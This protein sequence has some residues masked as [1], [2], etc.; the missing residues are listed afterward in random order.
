MSE[1]VPLLRQRRRR[2]V[3]AAIVLAGLIVA[4]RSGWLLVGRGDD[5]TTYDGAEIRVGRVIDGDTIEI[6]APDP[7]R[8]RSA[9]QVRLWGIDCPERAGPRRATAEP[10][11][12]EAHMLVRSLA[13]GRRV[14]IALEPHRTRDAYGRLLAHVDLPDGTSLNEAL[15]QA[16]LARADERWPH[17][18]LARYAQVERVARR[19][20]VGAWN[21]VE[22]DQ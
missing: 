6:E 7:R 13:D 19:A 17:A 14:R 1:R 15:L 9:T 2:W 21:G 22:A 10:F 20:G 8:R 11:A 3:I 16:G 5:M 12:D 4:D 18:L